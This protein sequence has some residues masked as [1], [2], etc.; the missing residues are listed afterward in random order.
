MTQFSLFPEP[1]KPEPAVVRSNDFDGMRGLTLWQPWASAVVLGTKHIENRPWKP[2]A[3]VI[4]RFI[5]IH[6]SAVVR[7]AGLRPVNEIQGTS[8]TKESL[9]TSA[10]IGFAR[11]TGFVEE[12]DDPWFTGPF[13]W[14]LVDRFAVDPIPCDGSQ[15]LWRVDGKPRNPK[16][17]APDVDRVR[18]AFLRGLPR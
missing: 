16:F 7:V 10:I 12:S 2:H 6:A 8:W 13:G 5:A 1:Q 14:T 17:K 11:V 4:G 15:L 18:Q 3:A 9:V